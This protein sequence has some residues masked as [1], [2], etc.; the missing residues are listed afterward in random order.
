MKRFLSCIEIFVVCLVV[1]V[2]L[3]SIDEKLNPE[4]QKWLVEEN[5]HPP[6][7]KNAYLYLMGF[8]CP[9]KESPLNAGMSR[10]DRILNGLEDQLD[11]KSVFPESGITVPCDLDDFDCLQRLFDNPDS[12][13][14]LIRDNSLYLKRYKELYQ[15]PAFS[16]LTDPTYLEQMPSA[17][18]LLRAQDVFFLEAVYLVSAGKVSSAVQNVIDDL[19]SNR[20]QLAAVDTLIDKMVRVVVLQRSIKFSVFL[21]RQEHISRYEKDKLLSVLNPLTQL[22]RSFDEVLKRELLFFVGLNESEDWWLLFSDFEDSLYGAPESFIYSVKKWLSK[23]NSAA[24]ERFP[25]WERLIEK[26]EMSPE[27]F[28]KVLKKTE[29]I[30][31]WPFW[32]KVYNPFLSAHAFPDA[33]TYYT[34]FARVHD[35]DCLLSLARAIV[36]SSSMEDLNSHGEINP[37]DGSEIKVENGEASYE[38]PFSE[39]KDGRSIK[40]IWGNDV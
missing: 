18:Q 6:D 34:Y 2:W 11:E 8:E 17:Y 23:P 19:G 28:N 25:E 40:V 32:Q 3:Y 14:S 20:R 10:V 22:E 33:D 7:E 1:L 13:L 36:Q 15:F 24:N 26:G 16:T 38:G 30:S 5:N 37:Y 21:M 4:I 9:E 12:I 29:S 31:G 27:Q 35:I 39:V